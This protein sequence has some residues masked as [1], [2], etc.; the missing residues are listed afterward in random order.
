MFPKPIIEDWAQRLIASAVDADEP[1]SETEIAT[2][3]VYE[4]LRRQLRAPVGEDGFQALASRAL[5]VAKA[6]SPKLRALQIMADG[7][8]GGV[9]E[10]DSRTSKDERREAGIIL[11]TQLLRLFITLLGEASAVRL[12]EGAESHIEAKG[13]LNVAGACIPPTVQNYLGPFENISLEA[14]RLRK[15]SEHLE[16]LADTHDGIDEII[17]VAGNIRSIANALDVFTLIRNKAG[18]GKNCVL[19]TTTSRYLN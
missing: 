12:I 3:R 4:K 7:S 6:Q 11:I 1:S 10:L 15:V 19:S 2:I 13:N 17:S 18:A 9:S 16:T 5:S 8:L 14:G